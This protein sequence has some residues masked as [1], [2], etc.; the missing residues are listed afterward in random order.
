MTYGTIPIDL[1]FRNFK[2]FCLRGLIA[3]YPDRERKE[4]DRYH[5]LGY[6]RS[7]ILFPCETIHLNYFMVFRSNEN[8]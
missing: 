2:I 1:K 4:E 7:S 3:S 5:Y 8:S 6:I